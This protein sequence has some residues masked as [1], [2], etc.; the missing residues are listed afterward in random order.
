MASEHAASAQTPQRRALELLI[1]S[2]WLI[3]EAAEEHLASSADEVAGR[4]EQDRTTPAIELRELANGKRRSQAD[5]QLEA[6]A[7][8]AAGKLRQASIDKA[9]PVTSAEVSDYYASHRRAFLVPERRY[10][11]IDN[12]LS[13][14]AALKAKREVESGRS[15]AQMSLREERSDVPGKN[16]GRRAIER[17]IF[18]TKPGVL[19]GPVLLSDIGYHSLFEVTRIVPASHESLEQ[20]KG[21]IERQLSAERQRQALATAVSRLTAKWIA[22]TDCA[23]RYVVA[24][25]RQYT[26]PPAAHARFELG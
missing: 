4:V 23:A 1:S 11:D 6:E 21:A 22:R 18:A 24:A 9:P 15:F 3:Q 16:P 20:A 13:Q 10:F 12:L 14:A 17:A 7:Q 2:D 5:L 26:G 25:C 8:L 19:S